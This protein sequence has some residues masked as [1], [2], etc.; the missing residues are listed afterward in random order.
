MRLWVPFLTALL[1]A[2][3]PVSANSDASALDALAN[4]YWQH[5]LEFDYYL[6]AQL[7]EPIETIRPLTYANADSD[8]AFAQGVLDALQGVDAAK[9][10][11]DRWLTYRT[12]EYLATNEV[13]NR[14]YFWL[15]QEATPYAGG[16]QLAYINSI[17]TGFTFSDR[18]DAQRYESLLHQYAGLIRSMHELLIGQHARGI[19]LP[20]VETD[21]SEAVFQGYAQ[22]AQSGALVP[23]QDRLKALAPADSAEL[24]S[25]AQQIVSS[26]IV[27]ALQAVATYL[28][29]SYRE[30]APAGVGLSQYPGGAE[31]YRYLVV[32]NTTLTIEPAKLHEMGLEAVAQLNGELDAIRREVGFH[33]DLRAF[34]AFLQSDPQFYV[35]TTEQFGDRLEVYVARAAAAVPKYFSHLPTAP[36]G[37]AP[38]PQ[39]LAG[40][41]TF[42]YYDQPTAARPKGI[43]LYNAWH[44][45]RTSALG[46]GALICHELIPGHH[47]QIALQQENA[48]LPNVRRYDFSE[49][50]FTEGWGEYASQLCWDM[51]V[52]ET[53]YDKAGRV[54]QDLMVSTRLVVDTG[55]NALGWSR[56]RAMQ[57]MRENLTLS[58]A[59]I[60][61]ESLRYSTD[62]PGQALAYKTGELT[63][64]RLRKEARASLGARFDIRKFHAWVI[65]SG[66]MTLD[67]LARH[68]EYEIA[69]QKRAHAAGP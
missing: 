36:Y 63:M 41:Q 52:Y 45:E 49:T 58:E 1:L 19:I 65:D 57:F 60:E 37:V 4:K 67:T 24:Q 69:R 39:E 59:Q 53:P 43:Y 26:E 62:I 48:S 38:L 54:M 46:A 27:P 6:R 18:S 17:L 33:G 61:T 47:F 22:P 35:K 15:R 40:S 50:G 10:D 3:S 25:A 13:A 16:S 64:L 12:L 66:S 34:K 2:V 44:P 20:N 9:L 30:G 51:G 21:A 14:T 68:V 29:G 7:G 31:Y 28:D 23:A 32:A 42:G 56:E 5:E 11:H 55:M 8:A